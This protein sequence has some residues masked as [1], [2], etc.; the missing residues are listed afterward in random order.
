MVDPGD[1]QAISTATVVMYRDAELYL[2]RLIASYI[3]RGIDAPT[4]AEDR[5][6]AVRDLR[7]A[8]E[9]VL[10][11]LQQQLEAG[12][13]QQVA[14]AYR[15]GVGAALTD[16]PADLAT[17]LAA[18]AAALTEVTRT[19]AIESLASALVSDVGER[20]SNVLRH[21]LDVY[22]AVVARASAVSAA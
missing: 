1:V 8:A 2:L 22:R 17:Q 11:E 19:A 4:W 6:R 5:L 9:D 14:E 3:A 12:A 20:H 15:L 13:A 7:I 10:G 16:L 18:R 21:V